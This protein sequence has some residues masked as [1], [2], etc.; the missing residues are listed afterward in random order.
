MLG[1]V[2][3]FELRVFEV[4]VVSY[5]SEVSGDLN[6]T[7]LFLFALQSAFKIKSGSISTKVANFPFLNITFQ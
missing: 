2:S 4:W 5:F 3:H 6:L 7:F 1:T